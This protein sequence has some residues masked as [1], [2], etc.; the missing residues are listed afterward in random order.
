MSLYL[1]EYIAR[2]LLNGANVVE[3]LPFDR[4]LG[5]VAPAGDANHVRVE[6]RSASHY[7]FQPSDVSGLALSTRLDRLS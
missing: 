7:Q 6:T 5:K 3:P 2:H 1:S 4:V